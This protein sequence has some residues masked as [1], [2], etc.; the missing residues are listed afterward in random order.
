MTYTRFQNPNAI[1]G[2]VRQICVYVCTPHFIHPIHIDSRQQTKNG[3]TDDNVYEREKW[4][5]ETPT[6]DRQKCSMLNGR[7][8]VN[9][10]GIRYSVLTVYNAVTNSHKKKS[11]IHQKTGLQL[12]C[13]L[14]TQKITEYVSSLASIKPTSYN[15]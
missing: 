3:D 6:F 7:F 13:S 2:K 11:T 9:R 10:F 4:V 15:C 8:N 1:P 12:S 14:L 5:W